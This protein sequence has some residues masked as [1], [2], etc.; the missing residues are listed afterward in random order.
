ML[1]RV[2]EPLLA[3]F[4]RGD[5]KQLGVRY[6]FP[7]LVELEHRNGSI[8][9]GLRAAARGEDS[10]TEVF[11][12]VAKKVTRSPIVSFRDGLQTLVDAVADA[13]QRND[14]GALQLGRRVSGLRP[15]GDPVGA[16]AYAVETEDGESWI[17]D[18]CVLAV[19]GRIASSLVKPFA[20]EVA[21][22]IAAVPYA[23]SLSV[24]LGYDQ[25]AAQDV[26]ETMGCLVPSIQGRPSLRLLDRQPEA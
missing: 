8:A 6:T 2:G 11:P 7:E 4:Y 1:D 12:G 13:I 10:D 26:P 20:P 9:K 5:A 21:K 3:G 19:P 25:R 17:A 23:S 18:I 14:T 22:G 15:A 24:H 16:A